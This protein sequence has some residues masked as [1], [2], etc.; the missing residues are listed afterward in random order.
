M[1]LVEWVK[2]QFSQSKTQASVPL[3][4]DYKVGGDI[5]RYGLEDWWFATFS[6]AERNIISDAYRP[7]G[8]SGRPLTEGSAFRQRELDQSSFLATLASWVAKP[9]YGDLAYRIAEKSWSLRELQSDKT[10]AHFTYTNLCKVFYRFR[11]TQPQA[12]EMAIWACEECIALSSK[13]N[14]KKIGGGVT[15]S[16][17][18]FKQLAII[19]E[20][21]ENYQR[22]IELSQTALEQGWAGDWESRISRLERKLS[23]SKK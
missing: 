17:Y 1:P 9:T 16:H 2:S 21:R 4:S 20:K 8:S 7:M 6:E 22:A 11:D 19:E 12:L 13:L 5:V 15:V 10:T 3:S 14:P 23:R 18:C